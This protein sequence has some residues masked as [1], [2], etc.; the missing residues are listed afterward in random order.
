M[1]GMVSTDQG[2]AVRYLERVN[3]EIVKAAA[4]RRQ[5]QGRG[6]GARPPAAIAGAPVQLVHLTGAAADPT[7]P[8]GYRTARRALP[9][10]LADLA[11]NDPRLAAA[12]M[13]ADACEKV[14][15]VKGVDLAG[16][17][18]KGGQSDGGATTRVKH[19]A[20][21]RLIEY[22]ANGWPVERG[23]GPVRRA[24]GMRPRVALAVKRGGSNR[25]QILAFDAIVAVCVDGDDLAAILRRHGWSAQ[26]FN[27]NPL[28]DAILA[29][30][31]DVATGLG[32]GRPA[33][34]QNA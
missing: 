29:T 5:R 2:R 10:L 23:H 33:P 25:Q 1:I 28:R 14:G 3:L 15:S 26:A 27:R 32:L 4:A 21:L 18:S 12:R 31:G 6:N 17:D 20:R 7:T 11:V 34:K 13:L 9:R 19:A 30:L 8:P 16:T 24:P 22:L